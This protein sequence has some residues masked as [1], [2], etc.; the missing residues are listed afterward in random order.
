MLLFVVKMVFLVCL[1]TLIFILHTCYG[2]INTG[3]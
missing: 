2:M 1:R 3:S